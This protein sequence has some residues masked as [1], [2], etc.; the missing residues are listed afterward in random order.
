MAFM[1]MVVLYAK[2]IPSNIE[3]TLFALF[4]GV[5]NAGG[6]IANLEGEFINELYIHVSK[7]N[8]DNYWILKVI[9][10][11]TSMFPLFFLYFLPTNLQT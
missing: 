11:V 6:I 1:P 2:I 3:A 8:L 7:D 9:S 4:T 5:S 10:F